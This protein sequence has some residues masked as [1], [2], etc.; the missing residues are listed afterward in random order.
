MFNLVA[1]PWIP[2]AVLVLLALAAR[3]LSKSWLTP[4]A[5]A[6]MIWS[7]YIALPLILAPEYEVSGAAVWLIVLLVFSIQLG[8]FCGEGNLS[9][10]GQTQAESRFGNAGILRFVLLFAGLAL[11]GAVYLAARTLAENDLSVSPLGILALGHILS[12][13]RYSGEQEPGIVRVL[14]TWMYPAGLLGGIAYAF[15]KTNLH[16]L[17]SFAALLSALLLGI[18]QSTRAPSLITM[19]CWLSGF[20]AT[21]S[22][23]TR[24]T[25]RLFTK[26]LGLAVVSLALAGIGLYVVLDAI[27]VYKQESVFEVVADW[28]R[29]KS[30]GFGHLAVFSEWV[31]HETPETLG[32]GA[33]T[34]AGLFDLVGLH[35]RTTG[36]YEQSVSLE[37]GLETNIYTIFRTL[38]QDFSLVGA[39]LVCFGFG[40]FSGRAYSKT[41]SGKEPKFGS[42][43]AFFSLLLLSPIISTIYNGLLLAWGVGWLFT[44]SLRHPT[45]PAK[46]QYLEPRFLNA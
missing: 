39:I 44:R 8:A 9:V 33:T 26:R 7:L 3:F 24:G 46:K 4:S 42:L 5:F 35:V 45:V 32:Y 43:A 37:G 13:A 25:Y 20:L 40:I 1:S 15:A 23:L 34:L 12:V 28:S 22:Y 16:K 6:P 41:I 29:V 17:G 2:T 18:I 27:R 36:T 31:K 14:V 38:I 11:I 21:K 10:S 19:C 30:S